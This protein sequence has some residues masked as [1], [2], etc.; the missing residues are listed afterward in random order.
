MREKE[1]K[2]SSGVGIFIT[3]TLKEMSFS[4]NKWSLK[5]FLCIIYSRVNSGWWHTDGFECSGHPAVQ[6][7][8]LYIS[9]K[10]EK[11]KRKICKKSK[12]K[13]RNFQDRL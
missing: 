8:F 3:M 2:A 11:K 1:T 4:K 10:Q 9:C 5:S 7:L 6:N 13:E 12:K